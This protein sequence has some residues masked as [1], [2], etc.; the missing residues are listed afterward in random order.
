M[1]CKRCAYF[2]LLD[3]V[4]LISL[5]GEKYFRGKKLILKHVFF[6]PKEVGT[7]KTLNSLKCSLNYSLVTRNTCRTCGCDK[8]I[9]CVA[10]DSIF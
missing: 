8:E 3:L 4:V 6:L 9:M 10:L 2:I 5:T 1:L 7:F